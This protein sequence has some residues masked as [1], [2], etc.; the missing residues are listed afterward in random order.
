MRMRMIFA[1]RSLMPF[2][3]ALLLWNLASTESLAGPK[4]PK[5]TPATEYV[6]HVL[7]A[8]GMM[9]VIH[10]DAF[11][12]DDAADAV[13]IAGRDG[14][15][16]SI[17]SAL[18]RLDAGFIK[19]GTRGYRVAFARRLL[20]S[21]GD[22]IILV[23]RNE[24]DFTAS[25]NSEDPLKPP[26]MPAGRANGKDLVIPP[27]AAVDARISS[28]GAGRA[29]ISSAA[30]VVFRSADDVEITDWGPG[31]AEVRDLRERKH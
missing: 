17:R 9:F 16:N 29:T 31:W 26:F 28:S 1:R 21:D 12:P 13:A 19:L 7:S 6:G 4:K 8:S 20:E 23:L 2:C 3:G 15:S 25:T 24:L 14:N 11:T 10:I 30:T 18:G 22:R 5:A 27:L